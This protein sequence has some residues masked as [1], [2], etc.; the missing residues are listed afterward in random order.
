MN[1]CL[2]VH[3]HNNILLLQYTFPSGSAP[4]TLKSIVWMTF[5]HWGSNTLFYRNKT[6]FR[7][8]QATLA[9]VSSYLTKHQKQKTNVTYWQ[10]A[11]TP[12]KL[13]TLKK[14]RNQPN[15]CPAT[16]TSPIHAVSFRWGNDE[17]RFECPWVHSGIWATSSCNQGGLRH[18]RKTTMMATS[19]RN[20]ITQYPEIQSGDVSITEWWTTLKKMSIFLFCSQLSTL[21]MHRS[22]AKPAKKR[23]P[24]GMSHVTWTCTIGKYVKHSFPRHLQGACVFWYILIL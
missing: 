8:N 1:S 24:T 19:R 14:P 13:V 18:Q 2:S 4:K 23:E 22:E 9:S 17:P 7:D 12:P 10:V 3:L 15:M 16:H 21:K 5:L 11:L 20:M 6:H